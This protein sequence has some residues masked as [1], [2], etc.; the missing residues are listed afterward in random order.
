MVRSRRS[1][2]ELNRALHELRRPLQAL[3]LIDEIAAGESKRPGLLQ[4]AAGALA[5]LDRAVNGGESSTPP[6]RFACRELVLATLERW[7]GERAQ[8]GG[9]KLSLSWRLGP[10][11]VE[12]DPLR[13]SQALDNVI[14]NALEHGSP[15]VMVTGTRA[16]GMVR[17]VVAN[18][19]TAHV[20][21]PRRQ[22]DPRHGH[23]L[24]VV[25]DTALAHGGRFAFSRTDAGAIAALEL[26]LAGPDLPLGS[27]Q[28]VRTA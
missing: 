4:L 22:R 23:G 27:D 15:P 3:M 8:G 10:A 25:S 12:G 7:R 2:G 28:F 6:R 13:I 9:G 14:S 24:R 18:A 5:D 26:P 19:H 21:R 11:P 17:I 1:R 20:V 16:G